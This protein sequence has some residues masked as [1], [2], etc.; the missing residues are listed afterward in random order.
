MTHTVFFQVGL[1]EDVPIE[2]TSRTEPVKKPNTAEGGNTELIG[3]TL[4]GSSLQ[5]VTTL[6]D[7]AP[8]TFTEVNEESLLKQGNASHEHGMLSM[9]V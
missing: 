3:E 6:K 4:D 8:A 7:F 5:N 2:S 1:V 9:Q